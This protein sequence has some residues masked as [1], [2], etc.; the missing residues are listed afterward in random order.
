MEG[1]GKGT[2]GIVLV[3]D[4][5]RVLMPTSGQG[6][7]FAIEDATVLA[8]C[9]LNYPPEGLDFST[10]LKEYTRRRLPR[11]RRMETVASF[12]ARLSVGRTWLQRVLR[13]Y[14]SGLFSVPM[15]DVATALGE[16]GEGGKRTERWWEDWTSDR[17]LLGE[18]FEVKEEKRE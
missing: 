10:A 13:D 6:A 15:G 17:W 2:G 9:L 18:R 7:A 12:A 14:V 5:G 3:G 1:E 8:S 16:D 4:A 11:Y